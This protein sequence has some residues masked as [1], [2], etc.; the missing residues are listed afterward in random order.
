M[1]KF[2]SALVTGGSGFI[3]SALIQRLAEERIDTVCVLRTRRGTQRTFAGM[4]TIAIDSFSL[5]ELR[6]ALADVSADVVFNLASYGVRQEDRDPDMLIR[7]NVELLA[8]LLQATR[9]WSLKRF[10]HTGSCAEYGLPADA[11][12]P[13]SE[14]SPL[15]PT[16]LYG[17]AKAAATLYGTALAAQFAV[18]F[19]TLRLFGV[20]G[21]GEAQERIIPYLIYRLRRHEMVDLTP[22]EQV[23]DLLHVDDVVEALM[24]G[25][26]GEQ[27]QNGR[28]YNISSAHGVRIRDIGQAV[29]EGLGKPQQLLQWGKRPYRADEPMWLVGDNRQ[30]IE[31][32]GWRP[33]VSLEDGIRRMIGASPEPQIEAGRHA[34]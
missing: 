19:I 15:H 17:A 1:R 2:S 7:G 34:L 6:R 10:I 28:V 21:T 8:N 11:L 25:A 29:A 16:S 4:R 9:H 5:E 20:Y 27:L 26:D 22:G 13:I 12:A 30:F 23:R 31:A 3:G 14:D 18:P 32:T 33:R 24:A